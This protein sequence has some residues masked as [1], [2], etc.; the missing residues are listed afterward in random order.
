MQLVEEAPAMATSDAERCRSDD[1][2]E[3]PVVTGRLEIADGDI[4]RCAIA[5]YFFRAHASGA[6]LQLK[7]IEEVFVLAKE[8]ESRRPRPSASA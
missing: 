2:A 1:P 3:S 7:P 6:A 5:P 8:K 4:V